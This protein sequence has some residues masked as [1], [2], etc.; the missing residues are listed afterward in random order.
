M[1]KGNN[2]VIIKGHF[3]KETL[4]L[5]LSNL[6][7]NQMLFLFYF[8]DIFIGTHNSNILN[9]PSSHNYSLSRKV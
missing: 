9:Y 4:L 1:T 7:V 3:F 6:T 5:L 2:G 8:N